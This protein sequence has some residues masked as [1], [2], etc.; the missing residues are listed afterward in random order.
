M[1]PFFQHRCPK[2]RSFVFHWLFIF[3]FPTSLPAQQWTAIHTI[4]SPNKEA[5]GELASDQNGN[6]YLSGTFEQS[7]E[8]GDQTIQ[9]LGFDDVFLSKYNV[10][11]EIE[12]TIS[13]GGSNFDQVSALSVDGEDNILWG[14]QFWIEG[15]FGSLQLPLIHDSRGIFLLKYK[16][17]GSLLWG[18]S[19]E[20][21]GLKTLTGIAS[22]ENNNIYLTGY[23]ENSIILADT[24]LK[25]VGSQS[26][27]LIK[28]NPEG[29]ILWA[30]SAGYLGTV[31]PKG[32]AVGKNQIFVGGDFFGRAVFSGDSIRTNT[33]DHDVFI[34]A[35]DSEGTELWGRK[36]GGVHEDYGHAIATDAQGNAYLTGTFFG[37]MK[38]SETL[39]IKSQGF[40]DNF[41]LI[42]YAPNG[43]PRLA[44][45]LGGE[46]DEDAHDLL[47]A[48][49]K[50]FIA[51]HYFGNLTYD[52]WSLSGSEDRFNT[53]V[54]AFDLDGNS[55]W[56][57]G[58][59]SSTYADGN[60]L[61]AGEDGKISLAGNFS[62]DLHLGYLSRAGAGLNDIFWAE[63][64]PSLPSGLSPDLEETSLIEVQ[65]SPNPGNGIFR[66]SWEAPAERE[67]LR[68]QILDTFGKP[69][70][71]VDLGTGAEDFVWDGNGLS[72]GIYFFRLLEKKGILSSGRILVL[73]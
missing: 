26:L 59:K 28:L 69:E 36:A 22:D 15:N 49:E 25:A 48:E 42:S 67:T 66:F 40:N 16:P 46:G 18:Q 39:E 35:Y 68:L 10:D 20:G 70:A 61:T 13:G 41:F 57:E 33:A 11:K 50:V 43:T 29:D 19:I 60:F 53:F 34:A 8:L 72:A 6:T 1:K 17:D 44:R 21:E 65:V 31:R 23:F 64:D 58:G 24:T 55:L 12:W 56:L 7:L 30:R 45:S 47:I 62:E 9:S 54:A 38:L 2:I 5:I 71:L 63:L 52:N 4:A 32:V 73:D 3:F 27:F 14:G 51:G 37:V